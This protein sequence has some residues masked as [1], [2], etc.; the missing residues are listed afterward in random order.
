VALLAA[1]K[2]G[3]FLSAGSYLS[4][5][6]NLMMVPSFVDGIPITHVLRTISP[7]F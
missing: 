7:G 6:F 5:H 3:L 4:M 1:T 2:N